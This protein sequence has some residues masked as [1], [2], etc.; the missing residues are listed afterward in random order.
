MALKKF[1][2][3]IYG[4]YFI[5][6]TDIYVFIIQLNRS[7]IDLPGVLIIRWLAQIRLFDLDIRYVF[8]YKY[9][10]ADRLLRHPPTEINNIKIKAE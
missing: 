6:K 4:V 3:W 1:R 5:I 2:L 9:T 7:G 8:K 10:A